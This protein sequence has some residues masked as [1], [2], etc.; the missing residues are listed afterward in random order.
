MSV[1]YQNPVWSGYFAD[2]FVLKRKGEYFAYGTGSCIHDDMK[3]DGRIFPMLHSTDL[4]HWEHIGSALEPLD[5]PCRSFYWAPE[6]VER[7]GMFFMFY[8]AGWGLPDENHHLRLAIADRPQGPFRD[9]GQVLLPKEHLSIDPHPFRDPKD[10]RWYLFF[11]RDYFDGRAGTGTAVVPLKDD[12]TPDGEPCTVLRATCDWHINARNYIGYN[13]FWDAW[14]T[15]EGPFVTFHNGLYYCFYS[16]GSWESDGYG[17]GYGVAEHPMG[18][19]CDDWNTEGPTVLRRIAGKVH[20]PGHI[21]VVTGPDNQT[22][23]MVYHAWDPAHTARRM[24]ID[25]LV[26]T[27]NGPRCLGPTTGPQT[28][29]TQAMARLQAEELLPNPQRSRGTRVGTGVRNPARVPGRRSWGRLVSKHSRLTH[30]PQ[31]TAA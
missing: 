1:K 17:V 11:A 6:V 22:Q 5:S 30:E 18:P 23:Y 3:C 28:L 29:A 15:V 16:G 13:K 9:T 7:E 10:G 8:S 14:H 27:P 20:G 19:Y 12:M 26:W 24:C 25:P 31:V 4:V 21:S 2:P